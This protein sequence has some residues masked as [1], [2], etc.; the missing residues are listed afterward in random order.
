MKFRYDPESDVLDIIFRD[1]TVLTKHLAADI[2]VDYD[3]DGGVVGI[4]VL[5]ASRRLGADIIGN[6]V[7]GA[8]GPAPSSVQDGPPSVYGRSP[9]LIISE[10]V[11]LSFLLEMANENYGNIIKAVVDVEKGMLALNG[12]LHSDEESALLIQGSRQEDLWGINIHPEQPFPNRIEFDSMV[13]VR[14]GQGNRT[15]GVDDPELR[16]R[17]LEVVSGMIVE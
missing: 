14:P 12:D 5:N 3:K 10:P 8:I 7:S 17:I 9:M 6:I 16:Q 1:A 4:E 15:R 2:A 11:P 13:N